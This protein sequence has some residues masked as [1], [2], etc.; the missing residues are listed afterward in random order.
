LTRACNSATGPMRRSISAR[1]ADFRLMADRGKQAHE[2]ADAIEALREATARRRVAIEGSPEHEAA[3]EEEARLN[4]LVL[5]LARQRN[6]REL[7]GG[8]AVERSV[9]TIRK[10]ACEQVL[11]R[12]PA[13]PSRTA[14]EAWIEALRVELAQAS[15]LG[16]QVVPDHQ[17]SSKRQSRIGSSRLIRGLANSENGSFATDAAQLVAAMI[18][19]RQSRTVS[20]IVS[21]R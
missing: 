8:V 11:D 13:G 15:A 1:F 12:T 20:Q 10:G 6:R 14:L 18:L 19:E 2:L 21:R 9:D 4:A 17:R 16:G 3:L 5:E 7:G